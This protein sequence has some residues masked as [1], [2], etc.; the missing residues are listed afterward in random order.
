MPVN[1]IYVMR[2]GEN[3]HKIGFSIKPL[4]RLRALRSPSMDIGLVASWERRLFGPKGTPVFGRPK[5]E[6][7]SKP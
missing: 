4:A 5:T 2:Y 6:R 7:K 3:L 1:Y